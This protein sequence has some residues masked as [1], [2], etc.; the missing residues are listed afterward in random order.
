MGSFDPFETAKHVAAQASQAAREVTG[1]A[2][3]AAAEIGEKAAA[4]VDEAAVLAA[5]VRE[6][7]ALHVGGIRELIVGK[8]VDIKDTALAGIKDL[9]DDFNQHLPALQEAGYTL[10]EVAIEVGLGPKVVATFACR[11]DI[12]QERVNSVIAEH[13]GA[14]VTVALLRALF[15]AYRVQNAIHVVGLKPRGISVEI[16]LPPAVVVKFA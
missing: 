1:R 14:K 3:S 6:Q 2:A 7:T 10:S 9:V 15:T 13:E 8:I 5:G 4:R 11:P 12:S 16:G